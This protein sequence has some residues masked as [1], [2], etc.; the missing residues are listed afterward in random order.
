MCYYWFVD[1]SLIRQ[2]AYDLFLVKTKDVQRC[3]WDEIRTRKL[4]RRGEDG[5]EKDGERDRDIKYW[6]NFRK[7][8]SR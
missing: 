8:S 3:M 1:Y 7:G 6:G 4:Y 5:S 2:K